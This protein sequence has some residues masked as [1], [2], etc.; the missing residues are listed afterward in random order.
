MLCDNGLQDQQPKYRRDNKKARIRKRAQINSHTHCQKEQAHQQALE[1][2]NI[3]FDLMLEFGFREQQTGQESPQCETKPR[4]TCRC[5][6][7]DG[8]QQRDGDKKFRR[9]RRS[10][11]TKQG[12][13]DDASEHVDGCRRCRRNPKP[14]AQSQPK[15]TA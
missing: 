6:G 15:T 7:A 8:G 4:G 14:L 10:G 1:R 12:P 13:Q 5:R 11:Q 3:D 2:L 9:P